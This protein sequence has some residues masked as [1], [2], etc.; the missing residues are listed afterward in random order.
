[1][2]HRQMG[3][4]VDCATPCWPSWTSRHHTC[5]H[6]LPMVK[7]TSLPCL[8]SM[9][10]IAHRANHC[11]RDFLTLFTECCFT[12]RS[13]Y[14]LRYRVCVHIRL[15]QGYTCFIELQCQEALL[16]EQQTMSTTT[17]LADRRGFHPLR[18]CCSKQTDCCRP[19]LVQNG[20]LQSHP[21]TFRNPK[22][23]EKPTLDESCTRAWSLHSP[24]LGQP[25]LCL[26]P[27]PTDM[28]KLGGSSNTSPDHLLP[29]IGH[30]EEHFCFFAALFA[31]CL[32]QE[33]QLRTLGM[34]MGEPPES[35]TSQTTRSG[36]DGKP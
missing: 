34:L 30:Q 13:F 24:L 36:L 22:S 5:L 25:Q 19:L 31:H 28:L 18:H 20:M 3:L 23:F 27:P 26:S 11:F 29:S 35:Q 14:F 17:G 15:L 2:V 6:R 10:S 33:R 12:V 7:T 16:H 1:M 32:I 9:R 4:P 21:S 8:L